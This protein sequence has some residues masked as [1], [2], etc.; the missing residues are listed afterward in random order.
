[1]QEA[2]VD[3]TTASDVKECIGELDCGLVEGYSSPVGKIFFDST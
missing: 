1:M 2:I 3:D